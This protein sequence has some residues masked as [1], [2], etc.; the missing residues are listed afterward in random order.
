MSEPKFFVNRARG[1]AAEGPFE[2]EQIVSWILAGKIQ[3]SALVCSEGKLRFT[4]ITGHP[5]FA[6]AV[7][8]ARGEPAP[9]E[10]AK[11]ARKPAVPRPKKNRGLLL[12]AIFA[13]FGI[14]IGAAGVGAY[15]MFNNGGTPAH[16]AVPSD[17]ELLLEIGSLHGVA[18]NL[19]AVRAFDANLASSAKLLDQAGA[20]L[21][22]RF[23]IAKPQATALVLAASSLG[24][25]ARHVASVPEGGM[26]L[27]FSSAKPVNALLGSKHFKYTGLVSTSGRVYQAVGAR[28]PPAGSTS[29]SIP[30]ASVLT[31]NSELVWFETSKVLFWGSPAFALSVAQALSLDA[32]SLAKNPRFQRA[33]QDF[34]AQADAIAYLDPGLLAPVLP[35]ELNALIGPF[36]TKVGPVAASFKLVPQGVRGHAVTRELAVKTAPSGAPP[37]AT[38]P[39]R[40]LTVID[41]LPS[42][43]FAYVAAATKPALSGDQ[44]VELMQHVLAK[45]DPD[46]GEQFGATLGVAETTLHTHMSDLYRSFGDQVAVAVLAPAEYRFERAPRAQILDKLAVLVVQT[47]TEDFP[48]RAFAAQLRAQLGRVDGVPPIQDD[49]NGYTVRNRSAGIAIQ[50]WFGQGYFGFAMGNDALVERAL[51]ALA[52][53][54]GMLSADPAHRAARAALPENAQLFAWVDTGRVMNGLLENPSLLPSVRDLLGPTAIRWTGPERV[55]EALALSW[56]PGPGG[57]TYRLETL[58]FPADYGI[59]WGLL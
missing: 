31:P 58:N 45:S 37:I 1:R 20:A 33:E 6:R 32:P 49:A 47:L 16:A 24:F 3:G 18:K 22:S 56:Q 19:A 26:V 4:P 9:A 53:G 28:P 41:R 38:A 7:R 43:T 50:L 46:F 36:L 51:K 52:S 5:P 23:E 15:V 14:A 57:Y 48:A 30:L 2:E 42:E 35:P 13:F 10:P 44:F 29:S 25:A 27:T 40:P 17:T 39:A 54:G 11:P 59:F 55:T 12:F 21:S 34:E 8:Q